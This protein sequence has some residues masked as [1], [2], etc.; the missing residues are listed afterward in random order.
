LFEIRC[1]QEA[2][3]ALVAIIPQGGR[4]LDSLTDELVHTFAQQEG[5]RTSENPR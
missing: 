2:G 1:R 4:Y 5:L 3:E